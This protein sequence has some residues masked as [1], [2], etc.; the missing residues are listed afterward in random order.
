[1]S[2]TQELPMDQSE[3][4]KLLLEECEVSPEQLEA[5]YKRQRLHGGK[6]CENLLALSIISKKKL[7]KLQHISPSAPKKIASTG[8]EFTFIADLLLK[9]I[10]SRSEFK[11]AELTDTVKLPMPIVEEV[12]E[13]LRRDNMVEVMGAGTYS[14]LSYTFRISEAGKQKAI[15]LMDT[16]H[17]AG[18]APVTLADYQSQMERQS[19]RNCQVTHEQLSAAFSHLIISDNFVRNIG[20]A[21][22]SGKSIFIYGPSGNGKTAIAEA[23]GDAFSDNVYIPYAVTVGGQI[24]TVYDPIN[25]IRVDS[26]HE[27]KRESSGFDQRWLKIK[28]PLVIT[29]GELSLRM[30]DLDFNPISK[31]YE[32]SLQMKANNG[33]FLV[34]DFGRQQADPSAFL[35]RWIVP[36]DRRVDF[37]S[38][39]TGMKFAIPFDM[40]VIFATNIKPSELGDE[41]FLR[42]IRY[43]FKIDY[44]SPAEYM[45]I[46]K[47]VCDLNG[48]AYE[49]DAYEHL[50]LHYAK[51]GIPLTSCHPR[52]FVEHILDY[53]LYHEEGAKLTKDAIDRAWDNHFGVNGTNMQEKLLSDGKY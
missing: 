7:S 20:P 51:T 6:L 36:L 40:I 13:T 39:H 25:H 45:E 29:G 8:L 31:F 15:R 38:L 10:Y 34:D 41:A 14:I 48:I 53:A 9:H 12:L 27:N 30:L 44:P 37:M 2:I 33:I 23:I 1:M 3:Q 42:R 43:K 26:Q 4:E 11:L 5:A 17:Y 46:F 50:M 18:P 28:R 24:I 16:C 22:N 52:D 49:E 35:N 19:I 21:I 32:A 47:R